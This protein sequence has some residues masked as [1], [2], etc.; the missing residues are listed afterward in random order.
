MENKL[1]HDK[2][3]LGGKFLNSGCSRILAHRITG[4]FFFNLTRGFEYN[5]FIF[6]L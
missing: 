6:G 2:H 1:L 5:H 4:F 3:V